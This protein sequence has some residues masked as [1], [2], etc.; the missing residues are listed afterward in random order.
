MKLLEVARALADRVE[1]RGELRRARRAA[2]A[3]A[4]ECASE[5]IGASE[6][7]SSWL[8]T[9]ITFFQ[10]CTSWRAQLA[11]QLAQQR[12]ARAR[13]RCSVKP[14]A[15]EVV[16]LLLAAVAR[17]REQA[18]AAARDRLAQRLG[19]ALRAASSSARPS[20]LRPL[21]EQ[22][23]RRD[24]ARRRRG[25]SASHQQHRDRRV[26]HHRVEQQLALARGAWRCS[27]S[28]SP[29]ALCAATS[30]P[31]S[32]SRCQREAER[33]VAVAV[34]RSRVPASA[35]NIASIG[36]QRRARS[37]RSRAAARTAQR[38]RAG[39]P[40]AGRASAAQRRGR[41]RRQ[42]RATSAHAPAARAAARSV[43]RARRCGRQAL[44][45]RGDARAAPCAG[46]APG[47]TARVARRPARS[48]RAR[49]QRRLDRL[50]VGL[51]GCARGRPRAPRQAEVA[52]RVI[53]VAVASSAA[54]CDRVLQLA[55][56]A[57]PRV[58][59]AAPSRA[60]SSSCLPAAEEVL[61]QRQDVVGALGQRRQRAARS[62]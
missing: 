59:A 17:R 30:S 45:S 35:R 56:V 51:V 12:A 53:D 46:T 37:R 60:P 62:R 52:R 33:E 61:G 44:S 11:R 40:A 42:P 49:A 4:P 9:R 14:R 47:A 43:S 27:R 13:G 19:R 5:A 22:L 18:V 6:L 24:V 25:R 8:I 23:A 2:P 16:D 28:T 50:A 20:S 41:A 57:R 38:D 26:L 32:S 21:V 1:H 15:R 39:Q 29:S 7:L 10:V 58:R 55:H 3:R 31:S 48:R 54:R 36:A 34:A